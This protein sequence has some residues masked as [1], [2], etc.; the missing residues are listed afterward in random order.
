MDRRKAMRIAVTGSTGFIGSRLVRAL[1]A[2]G[3]EV[4]RLVRGPKG[5]GEPEIVFRPEDDVIDRN[6]LAGVDAVVNLAGENIAG[7]WTASKRQAIRRSR[8]K[9]T[10]FLA[11]VL[12]SLPNPPKVLVSASAIGYYGDRG[13]EIL[14]ESSAPGTGFLATVCQ[15]WETATQAAEE[16]GIRVVKLRIGGV[17]DPSGAMLGKMRIPFLLGLGGRFGDGRQYLSWITLDDLVEVIKLAL[18]RDAL[19][20]PVNAV[21][22]DPV[23]NAEFTRALAKALRRPA[24]LPAPRPVL[25]MLFGDMAREVLLASQRVAPRVL[26]EHEFHYRDA[27]LGQALNRLLGS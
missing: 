26:T 21:S 10:S 9:G 22:P 11:E 19:S 8:V 1:V 27:Q 17:L 2:D 13:D 24:L 5:T 3:H 14:N 16:A 20:G 4:V 23:T 6:A 18:R 7:L 15:E 12:A 25:E